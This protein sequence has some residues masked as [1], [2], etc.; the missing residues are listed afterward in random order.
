MSHQVDVG[1]SVAD[2]ARLAKQASRRWALFTQ[3][4]KDDALRAIARR[5]KQDETEI[6]AANREDIMAAEAEGRP[7]S[8]LDRLRLTPKRIDELVESVEALADLPDPIGEVTER[9]TQPNGLVIQ[10]VRVPLGVIGMVYEARPNV[11]VDAAGI[12]LK[13]GNAIVLRGSRSAKR[14]NLALANSMQDALQSLQMPHE[15]I[16]YLL[17]DQHESVDALCTLNEFIDVIIPRGGAELIQRVVRKSTVPVLETG[18]GN[19]HLFVD[20][21][22]LYEM[23]E[24]IVLN[25]KTS[26]PSVCNAAETLLIH[27]KWPREQT[28]SLLQRLVEAGVELRACELTRSNCPELA[29]ALKPATEEDWHTEYL[30][31]I[32]SVRTV[33]SLETALSHIEQYGSA[34][35]EAI[36]TETEANARRFLA[37]VDAAAVYHNASTRFTDGGQF[38]F[39]AEIGISTQK[40]H[41]RG[42]MGLRALTST[43]YQILGTGQIR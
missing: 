20:E 39:G 27:S 28:L 43:K 32:M 33:D 18:V 21:S 11:T 13:T 7:E 23:A 42:P 9:W 24:A 12:A 3:E 16:Q 29:D 30:E 36:I 4:E 35:S 5:L 34:H 1:A 8:Y 25:A 17:A 41:A 2:Q 19:C 15:A 6:L 40:I 10:S 14:S 26:R 31:L 37:A 38:G 22:A